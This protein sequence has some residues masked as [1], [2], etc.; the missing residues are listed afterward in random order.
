MMKCMETQ[1][2]LNIFLSMLVSSTELATQ[3][4]LLLPS[5][6][7]DP[8]AA[9]VPASGEPGRD[10]HPADLPGPPRHQEAGGIGGLV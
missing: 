1:T 10:G 2:L 6:Q 7:H 5:A 8:E 9:G 4:Q 3:N